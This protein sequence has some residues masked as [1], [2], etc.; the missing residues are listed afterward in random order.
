MTWFIQRS[1]SS[2]TATAVAHPNI[3]FI[4]YWGNIDALLRIPANSSISMN[5]ADL[6]TKSM[7]KFDS[8]LRKDTLSIN[9]VEMKGE[10]LSRVS[11]YLDIVRQIAG[12]NIYA[13][14]KSTQNFPKS[15]GLASS[16]SA[17]AALSLAAT[18]VLGI[19]LCERD[20]S[21]LARRGSG[22]ACRSI[23]A[24]FVEWHA[25]TCDEDSYAFSIAQPDY[26]QLVD[27]IAI[28][29]D[30]VK[31]TSSSNGHSLADSSIFQRIRVEDAPRRLSICRKAI[32]ERDFEA[33]ADSI[34]LDS[35]L[36]HAVMMTSQPP[37]FYWQPASLNIMQNVV[38]W[39]KSG[40]PACYTIDAGANVHVITEKPYLDKIKSNLEAIAGVKYVLYSHPGN[41]AKVIDSLS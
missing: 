17:F 28:I 2:S 6:S 26:W 9:N 11:D 31:H 29:T 18:T 20:L 39:R 8:S 21:R 12:K 19:E 16:A 14:V 10:G 1:M 23:P 41:G 7:V 24:G 27:C 40:L 13:E 5:L 32:Q 22:S 35:N 15:A 33:L 25:G 4:K 36:M 37:L 30:E 38:S 34:E 3:A